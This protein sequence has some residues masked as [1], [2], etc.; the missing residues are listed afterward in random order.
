LLNGPDPKRNE[1]ANNLGNQYGFTDRLDY[2]FAKNVYAINSSKVIGNI[3]PDGSSIWDCGT[4]KCFASDHA[5]ILATIE[6]PR[7][8]NSQDPALADHARFPLGIWHFL[9]I[10]LVSFLSWRIARRFRRR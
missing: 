9:A 1:F 2:V 5:G 4:E 6:I 10:A 7:G 3:Y 8:A